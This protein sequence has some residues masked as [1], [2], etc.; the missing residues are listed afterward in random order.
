MVYFYFSKNRLKQLFSNEEWVD[1]TPLQDRHRIADELVNNYCR[2]T[3]LDSHVPRKL[4]ISVKLLLFRYYLNHVCCLYALVEDM[5]LRY[6]NV[7]V[8]RKGIKRLYAFDGM[9]DVVF[10]SRYALALMFKTA[11][12]FIRGVKGRGS[13]TSDGRSDQAMVDVLLLHEGQGNL[14]KGI[15]K[16]ISRSFSGTYRF[17]GIPTVT[18]VPSDWFYRPA[19]DVVS[20]FEQDL[21]YF[22]NRVPLIVLRSIAN[23]FYHLYKFLTCHPCKVIVTFEQASPTSALLSYIAGLMNKTS[24]SLAHAPTFGENY[25]HNPCDYCLVFGRSSQESFERP[26]SINCG[27]ILAIGSPNSDRA[28]KSVTKRKPWNNDVLFL[29]NYVKPNRDSEQ[30][31]TFQ[32]I[33]RFIKT[34]PKIR[35]T[36]KPHP[37]QENPHIQRYFSC[38]PEVEILDRTADL[39]SQIDH[40]DVVIILGWSASG[41]EVVIRRKPM[42]RLNLFNTQDWFGYARSGYAH[43]AQDYE[44]L[45]R[46]FRKMQAKNTVDLSARSKLLNRH[47]ANQGWSADRAARFLTAQVAGVPMEA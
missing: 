16:E 29:P 18:A 15:W 42:I 8:I 10:P 28:F 22:K 33:R 32:V 44:G 30:D 46:A 37:A 24:V 9:R 26:D 17:R 36:V 19:S 12:G 35:L 43:E 23:H 31:M 41:L 25:K 39:C 3:G 38:L 40:H 2:T 21:G 13:C 7:C 27:Q 5:G 6:R 1:N 20:R 4:L 34:F 11:L 47:F 45:C 14:E